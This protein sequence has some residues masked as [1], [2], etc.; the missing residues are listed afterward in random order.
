VESARVLTARGENTRRRIVAAAA[1]LVH[2]QGLAATTNE[3]VRAAAAVSGSQLGHYFADKDALVCAVVDLQDDRVLGHEKA[4]WARVHDLAGL[5][6]WRDEIVAAH[7]DAAS[8]RGGCPMGSL[9]VALSEAGEQSRQQVAHV[10]ERWQVVIEG[11]LQRLR[12]GGD[13][14]ADC[15]TT[16]L[17][18]AVLA[19]LQ[20]G[21]MLAQVH[22]DAAP[23]A[24]ALDTMVAHIE[25][26]AATPP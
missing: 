11:G 6:A 13:L 19:S 18:T 1:D 25:A 8:C 10:L 24:A 16:R 9:A 3:Q 23:L 22:R 4:A 12:G 7:Q 20:G 5:R 17:A 15:D 14:P 26:L 2:E 21:L